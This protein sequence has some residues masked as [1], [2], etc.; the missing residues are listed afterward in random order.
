MVLNNNSGFWPYT[1]FPIVLFLSFLSPWLVYV[2]LLSLAFY[3][4]RLP[5]IAP[6]VLAAGWLVSLLNPGLFVSFPGLFA[7]KMVIILFTLLSSFRL[8]IKGNC[9]L[10][11]ATMSLGIFCFIAIIS[12]IFSSTFM[13]AFLKA[14]L[15]AVGSMSIMT[16]ADAGYI[17][18]RF[19]TWLYLSL[20]SIVIF[21]IPTFFL[22]VGY[23][24][25][26]VG[27][28]GILN[29]PQAFGLVN[30]IISV[31][32]FGIII[33]E[34]RHRYFSYTA[35][36]VLP[37]ALL[38]LLSSEARIGILT[39]SIC[40]SAMLIMKMIKT[41]N[42]YGKLFI[43]I[44]IFVAMVGM[45]TF[46]QEI[47]EILL[48]R[49]EG[50]NNLLELYWESRG[51][52]IQHSLL[53]FQNSP[54]IGIG[55]GVPSDISNAE[56]TYAL[57]LPVSLP[58]EKGLFI[59]A[60]L[61]ETGILGFLSFCIVML[62]IFVKSRGIGRWLVITVFLLNLTETTLFSLSGFGL[63]GWLI[64]AASPWRTQDEN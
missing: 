47:W 8:F 63:I 2:L 25:N 23:L 20:A 42:T 40:A 9:R 58:V 16:L 7:V 1:T 57:G 41:N 22:D 30:S 13:I 37:I 48:K 60:L 52:I 51:F 54:I 27:F 28:Q 62:L 39:F 14:A 38:F 44:A 43:I 64:I 18:E 55:F 4:I 61:E 59:T 24:R 21:S 32:S 17:R 50:P 53:N 15:F 29:H 46:Q 31:W 35:I 26:G 45:F 49:R 56:I 6:L 33:N 19:Y 3:A 11:S 5:Q 34:T 36:F 10:N 12:A